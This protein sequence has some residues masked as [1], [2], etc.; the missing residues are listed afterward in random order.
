[1]G[2]FER[3]PDFRDRTHNLR[4]F[5]A[6]QYSYYYFGLPKRALKILVPSIITVRFH[7]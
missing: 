3:N 5:A 2:Q 4:H 1:M 6:M 7:Y